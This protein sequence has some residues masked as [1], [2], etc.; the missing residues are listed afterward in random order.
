MTC[1]TKHPDKLGKST[2]TRTRRAGGPSGRTRMGILVA[3]AAA[4]VAVVAL[5]PASN[6][7][8][9]ETNEGGSCDGCH[10]AGGTSLMTVTG[11]PVGSYNPGQ[12]YV[13]TITIADANGVS[14]SNAFD[15][16]VSAG[17]LT[18]TDANAEINSATEAS[19]ADSGDFTVS[20]WTVT[21]TAP[22]SGSVSFDI[23]GVYG[24]SGGAPSDLYEHESY[25]ISEIPEFPM[26]LFPVIGMIGAVLAV[27][28]FRKKQ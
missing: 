20:S 17:T 4:V 19:S 5:L 10:G 18:E 15:M 13:I 2:E 25:N 21:W 24:T 9:L 1:N 3:I 28:V 14:E 16:I 27:S 6:S 12:D 8:A 11:L 22:A 26:V 7:T 23:W